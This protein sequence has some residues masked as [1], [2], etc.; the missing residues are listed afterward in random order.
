[1]CGICGFSTADAVDKKRFEAMIDLV[2]HRGP[3]GRGSFYMD[4]PPEQATACRG[5][6][7]LGHRRLAILDLSPDGSQ[8]FFYKDRYVAVYNGEIYNYLELKNT[9]QQRGYAFSTTCDTEVLLAAYDC[10][11]EACVEQFNGM[12]AFCIYDKVENRLF[13]SRDRFGIKPFYYYHNDEFAFAS[14]IKQLLHM[15]DTGPLANQNMLNRFLVLGEMD[16]T[17][18]TLFEGIY[19]L[20]AGHNLM[21]DL[22]TRSLSVWQWYTLQAPR[23][24]DA[25]TYEQACARFAADFSQSISLRLRA[26]VAVGSC[27]SGGIDSSAIVGEIH[28]QL[29]EQGKTE[30]QHTVSSCYDEKEFNEQ[31]Y[32]EAVLEKTGAVGHSIFPKIDNDPSWMDKLIWHADEPVSS[33]SGYSQWCVFKEARRQNLTVML[34]G[35]GA[36]EQLAGYSQFHLVY[37]VELLRKRHFKDFRRELNA[38]KRIRAPYQPVSTLSVAAFC[39][40]TALFPKGLMRCINSLFIRLRKPKVFSHPVW[41]KI[42]LSSRQYTVPPTRDYILDNINGHLKLLL[43]M[44]DRNSMAHSIEAR[45][46]F[47]DPVLVED[48]FAM[49][50]GYKMR[51]G[52]SKAVLR[53]AEKPVLPQKVYDRHNKMGF[54]APEA[55]WIRLNQDW[56]RGEL[57]EACVRFNGI[58]DKNAVMSGFEDYLK[59]PQTGEFVWWRIMSA[60][61]WAKLFNVQMPATGR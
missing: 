13:C 41:K 56:F 46:P 11:G 48:A 22:S 21:F 55:T 12:W 59:A 28:R 4:F 23:G 37:F 24:E 6:L 49:P 42:L 34:D 26:D 10:F 58:L 60:N 30:L 39:I 29:A 45:V 1:M 18:E 20:A 27:L 53:D 15:Q 7:A 61:R 51:D 40:M 8:P 44:E 57:E 47:L 54:P 32:I 33:S 5:G 16:E 14:E 38:Y 36:D 25:E 43:H 52:I 17:P 35:Q 9:L 19:Q 31:E 2:E 50:F 3:D